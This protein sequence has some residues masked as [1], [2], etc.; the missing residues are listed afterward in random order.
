[1]DLQRDFLA[2][3]GGR[4]PVDPL[5]AAAVI[6]VAND[7]LAKRLLPGALPILMH[8]Q[9]PNSDRIGNFFRHRA[10]LAGSAGAAIDP[11]IQGIEHAAVIEMCHPSAFSSATLDTLLREYGVRE[12]YILGVFAEGC[13]RATAV[14]AVRRGFIVRAIEDAVASDS[15]WK[16]RFGLWS[17][18]H[19]GATLV[20]SQS[21]ERLA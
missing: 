1:M 20:A 5:G 14:D 4:M 2:H 15:A 7:V 9:F 17:M 8:S 12:L 11:R 13:V 19:A 3:D 10:A 18:K 6:D 16:R 21:L